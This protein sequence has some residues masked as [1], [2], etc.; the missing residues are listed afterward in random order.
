M[1]A[2]FDGF[3]ASQEVK[4]QGK[5]HDEQVST[6]PTLSTQV[7]EDELKNFDERQRLISFDKNHDGHINFSEV[8]EYTKDY[9]FRH[10]HDKDGLTFD[11]KHIFDAN[12]D[13]V[14][15]PNELKAVQDPLIKDT[16]L[17]CIDFSQAKKDI[18]GNISLDEFLKAA[19]SKSSQNQSLQISLLYA[20]DLMRIFDKNKDRLLDYSVPPPPAQ[21]AG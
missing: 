15:Q 4:H 12:G 17:G 13:G 10:L 20:Q 6:Q 21:P 7:F 3:S 5:E 8:W 14:L 9:E 19:A 1:S 2:V 18:N 11:F 16:P